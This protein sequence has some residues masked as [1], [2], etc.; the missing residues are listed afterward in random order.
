MHEDIIQF[1]LLTSN[2]EESNF[3]I[4]RLR[5]WF[6]PGTLIP[7]VCILIG[8]RL[9]FLFVFVLELLLL[10][11]EI[12][13]STVSNPNLAF[14]EVG[15][16]EMFWPPLPSVDISVSSENSAAST[17]E[18]S[19]SAVIPLWASFLME[20]SLFNV[21]V[22]IPLLETRIWSSQLFPSPLITGEDVDLDI[23]VESPSPM[24][25]WLSELTVQFLFEILMLYK[26]VKL[27]I[28]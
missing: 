7:S 13:S 14:F 19:Q 26:P 6:N 24:L 15:L 25:A 11:I 22:F 28:I 27:R 9:L 8:V 17:L 10:L 18:A 20:Q 4:S 16:P 12:C 23:G 2:S 1:C 3:V 21:V 5:S